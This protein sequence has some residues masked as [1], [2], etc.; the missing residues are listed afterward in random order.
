MKSPQ[1]EIKF[2][3]LCVDNKIAS[4]TNVLKALVI[5]NSQSSGSCGNVLEKHLWFLKQIPIVIFL[6]YL[7]KILL[8]L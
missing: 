7:S 8:L 6:G 1:Q 5:L 3:I 4:E 2:T